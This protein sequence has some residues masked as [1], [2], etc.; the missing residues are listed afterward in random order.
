[1]FWIGLLA[2]HSGAGQKADSHPTKLDSGQESSAADSTPALDAD[3]VTLDGSCAR[4][5]RW[6]GFDVVSYPEYGLVSG[7]VLDGV[8]PTAVLTTIGTAGECTLLRRENPYCNPTCGSDQT[9]DL[10]GTCVPYPLGL[11][12]GELSMSGLVEP[13]VMSPTEPGMLYYY[14]RIANP[15]YAPGEVAALI[16]GESTLLSEPLA[17]HGVG[18]EALEGV[19]TAW[20]L[21]VG[22]GLTVNWRAPVAESRA[23]LQLVL[24]I[25]QH[26]V[27]PARIECDLEDDGAGEIPGDLLDRLLSMGVTGFPRGTLSRRT[28]DRAE[29]GDGCLD[30]LVRNELS[31]T[32]AV[33][34]HVPWDE[35]SDCPEG[36]S[37]DLA[38]ET[39]G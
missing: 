6:G 23:R 19:D 28:A 14:T 9:C 37:C 30:L 39:C 22:R 21:G 17:L 24:T 29:I 15:P 33:E 31:V 2:C 1:M 32:V 18:V 7:T 26:G 27:S 10:S 38:V 35:Q 5:S 20:V 12:L 8:V 11:S 34:G 16:G 13:V 25:D 3:T 36:T 4:E